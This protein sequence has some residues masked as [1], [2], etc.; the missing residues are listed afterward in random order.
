MENP[1]WVQAALAELGQREV[2]GV[3]HNPRI[4]EY[5]RR[6]SLR[7]Q[8]DEVAWCASFVN[9]VLFQVGLPGTNSAAARSFETY[10]VKVDKPI[11]GCIVVLARSGGG[12]VGFY[13]GERDGK[14]LVLGGNQSNSVSIALYDRAQLL[15]YRW[16]A[17]VALPVAAQP[18]AHSGVIRGNLLAMLGSAGLS[19]GVL[20]EHASSFDQAISWIKNGGWAGIVLGVVVFSGLLWSI[21]SRARGKADA[22]LPPGGDLA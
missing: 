7:A 8:T 5:H 12:H 20:V 22:A 13:M 3:E 10:G 19:A 16:P 21:L 2:R 6:T 1:T 11:T 15:C 17:Q 9:W 18:L 4:V 14:L